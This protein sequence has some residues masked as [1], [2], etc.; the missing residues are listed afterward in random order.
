M[1][2]AKALL[3][4]AQYRA[5]LVVASEV[6]S[7]RLSSPQI[8]GAF[9]G[10]F[11]DGA[12]AFVLARCEKAQDN[13]PRLGNF[14]WGCSGTFASSLRLSLSDAGNLNIQFKG[15]QLATAAV[16]QLDRVID[17][18]ERLSGKPRAAVDY[19]AIHEPNPRVV[20]VFAQRAKIP[21][22]KIALISE[23]CGNLGS[24]TCGIS[25]CTAMTKASTYRDEVRRPLIYIAAAGPGLIWGGSYLY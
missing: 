7:R 15:V 1:A 2:T 24:A 5:A 14:V 21:L 16:T 4:T 25:L 12:C 10:L 20:G 18:L 19:F 11:G 13:N 3:S 23:T 9:R 8:P 22:E 6:N 17:H